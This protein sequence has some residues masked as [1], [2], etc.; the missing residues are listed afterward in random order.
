[1]W[2]KH[3]RWCHDTSHDNFRSLKNK[4]GFL[5]KN[6]AKFISVA[7]DYPEIPET[8]LEENGEEKNLR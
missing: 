8:V 5:T 1:M 7:S 6:A 3:A 2:K 4:D